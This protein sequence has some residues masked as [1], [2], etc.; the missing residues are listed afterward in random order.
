MATSE[1]THPLILTLAG[2]GFH[3]A[4]IAD[5]VEQAIGETV[6]ASQVYACCSKHGVR[7]RD[8]RNGKTPIAQKIL[9]GSTMAAR[10]NTQR[11]HRRKRAG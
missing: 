5:W 8:Y 6:T 4:T 9:R 10:H 7:L 3:A 1:R 11:R 2:Y